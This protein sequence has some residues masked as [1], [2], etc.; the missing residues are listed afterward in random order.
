MTE[1]TDDMMKSVLKLMRAMRRRPVR[2]AHEFPPAVGRVLM[3]LKDNDGVSP[4][5]LC[6]K[7]DVRPSSMSELLGR[8]E[9]HG[10]V[11]RK[12]NE[13]DKRATKV[14]LTDKGREGV[15]K[16][17]SKFGAENEKLA[18]CFTEDEL[19]TFCALCDKLSAHM[20]RIAAEEGV[21]EGPCRPHRPCGPR[22]EHMPF[23][24]PHDP[25]RK[26]FGGPRGGKGFGGPAGPAFIVLP[27]APWR[28]RH[29]GGPCGH[30]GFHGFRPMI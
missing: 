30:H 10:L 29:F 13:A 17:A 12:E 4:A 22:A 15:E 16:M 24:G 28:P 21:K 2:P 9:A 1:K 23:G 25:G 6:E 18:A 20:E 3:I 8:M 26:G 11:E 14:L 27:V 19:Q 7:M 5:E